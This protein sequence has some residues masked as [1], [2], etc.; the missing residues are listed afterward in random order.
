MN[1][2]LKIYIMQNFTKGE[3]TLISEGRERFGASVDEVK[4]IISDL[5]AVR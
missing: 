3:K 4:S 2:D 5:M 1:L